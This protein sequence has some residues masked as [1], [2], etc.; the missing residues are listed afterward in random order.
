MASGR[1]PSFAKHWHSALT[2][3]QVRDLLVLVN[4]VYRRDELT[5]DELKAAS[6][7]VAVAVDTG[8]E[9]RERTEL[10]ADERHKIEMQRAISCSI[11]DP[12]WVK[13]LRQLEVAN[14]P[15]HAV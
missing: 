15:N 4:K 14:Q 2:I 9:R 5:K 1:K 3:D 8:Y 12:L 10:T 6:D 11:R 13:L 7:L